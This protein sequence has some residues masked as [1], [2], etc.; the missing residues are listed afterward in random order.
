MTKVRNDVSWEAELSL[1]KEALQKEQGGFS[2]DSK[3]K[4][5]FRSHPPP[6]HKKFKLQKH[7]GTV[8]EK[9]KFMFLRPLQEVPNSANAARLQ[10]ET[11]ELA[12]TS[13]TGDLQG[14]TLGHGDHRGTSAGCH[15]H[16]MAEH[17]G[18]P[19]RFREGL[20]QA[21]AYMAMAEFVASLAR[22][23][24]KHKLHTRYF[25]IENSQSSRMRYVH[26]VQS[27]T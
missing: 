23:Q 3:K 11:V 13:E 18:H 24:F 16:A 6:V 22:N 9:E 8:S 19:T 7:M 2:A 25:I 1:R 20:G 27:V 21:Q 10:D 26:C 17:A 4:E 15:P 12:L 5:Q 14:T